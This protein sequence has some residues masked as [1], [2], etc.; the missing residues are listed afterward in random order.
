MGFQVEFIH[1]K[2][3]ASV[4]V[5]GTGMGLLERPD[6]VYFTPVLAIAGIDNLKPVARPP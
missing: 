1:Q 3:A 5:N 2:S 6:S 4:Q